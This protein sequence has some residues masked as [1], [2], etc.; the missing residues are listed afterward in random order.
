[1]DDLYDEYDFSF[2]FFNFC[3]PPSLDFLSYVALIN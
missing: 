2:F 3:L 1:M